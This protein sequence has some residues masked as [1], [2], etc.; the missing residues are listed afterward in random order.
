LEIIDDVIYDFAKS[1]PF[2]IGAAGLTGRDGRVAGY[3]T[4]TWCCR[5]F[6]KNNVIDPWCMVVVVAFAACIFVGK[7]FHTGEELEL[8]G[9]GGYDRFGL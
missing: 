9:E 2:Y 7:V 4:K 8:R 3:L 6:F 5:G 1:R